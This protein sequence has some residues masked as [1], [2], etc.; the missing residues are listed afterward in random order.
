MKEVKSPIPFGLLLVV[1]LPA[2]GQHHQPLVTFESPTVCQGC[3]WLLAL[4][5]QNRYRFAA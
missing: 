3:P 1:T 4:G 2:F 5:G